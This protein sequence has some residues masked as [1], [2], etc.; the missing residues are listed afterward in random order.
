[1][2]LGYYGDKPKSMAGKTK[3]FDWFVSKFGGS[4]SVLQKAIIDALPSKEDTKSVI[5][6]QCECCKQSM[7]L[8]AQIHAPQSLCQTSSP[9]TGLNA[10]AEN[11]VLSPK[12]KAPQGEDDEEIRVIIIL[13]CN[14]KRCWKLGRATYVHIFCSHSE[15]F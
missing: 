3:E 9:P 5:L 8:V 2:Y 11:S 10:I 12:Y 4:I 14:E 1:M 7:S 15:S 13:A 6:S